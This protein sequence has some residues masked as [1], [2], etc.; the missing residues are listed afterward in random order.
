MTTPTVR[1]GDVIEITSGFAFDSALFGKNGDGL[2]LVRIRDV[3][4][5][6]SDT[7]YCGEYDPQYVVSDGDLLVSMDGDFR[8]AP[9]EGGKAVLNQRV[10]RIEPVEGKA[11][12]PYLRHLL[13]KELKRIEDATPFVTV[14]HLSVKTIREIRLSLPPLSEQ[15]RIAAILDK[16]DAIRRKR[17]EGIRLTE[18][19]LRSTFLEMFGDPVNN[20]KGWDVVPLG[21]VIA[22][23]PQNGLYR[24]SSDYGSGTLIARIDTFCGG[25]ILTSTSINKRVRLDDST[26]TLY[27]LRD[28]DL[29]INR[30]N[31]RSHLGKAAV[32]TDLQEPVV[33]ESN[34][35]RVSLN[36]DRANPLYVLKMLGQ[37]A[38]NRQIQR[39]A[40]DAV[41]QS[42]INQTD[43]KNFVLPLPPLSV[44][45]H[46]AA[47]HKRIIRLQ[48]K[49]ERAKSEHEALLAVLIKRAF[50]GEL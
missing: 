13:P 33:F 23:G 47:V 43:V 46:Y 17:E 26:Q 4:R 15:R 38:L 12:G 8:I 41:N 7:R 11:H 29:L 9:W 2:P 36:A 25:E 20:P 44:Q 34:M 37:P 31:S 32:V 22:E 40:K 27:L 5:G 48:E 6:Y 39:A 30:V 10:C 16:A 18:E 50:R 14:K 42:S 21:E 1:L 19:L 45:Q 49:R 35:M 3:E 28:G 24:P